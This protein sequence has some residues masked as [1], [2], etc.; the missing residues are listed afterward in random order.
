MR[1]AHTWNG[2]V[3]RL[4]RLLVRSR[5]KL[6]RTQ[7]WM[8]SKLNRSRGAIVHMENGHRIPSAHRL[9]RIA[10]CYGVE[11]DQV[12]RA[13]EYDARGKS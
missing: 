2:G 10:K 1:P 7:E 13:F 5:L 9:R 12:L 6:G 4:G 11:V 8:A 3:G